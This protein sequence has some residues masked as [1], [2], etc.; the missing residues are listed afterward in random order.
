[1]IDISD[2]NASRHI[3]TTTNVINELGV[4]NTDSLL[5]FNK[6]DKLTD[7]EILKAEVQ[8]N[9]GAITISSKMETDLILFATQS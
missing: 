2:P 7:S 1:M 6:V 9:P 5:V 4:E 3:Q 8:R